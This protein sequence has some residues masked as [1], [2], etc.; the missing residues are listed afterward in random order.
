MPL[1]HWSWNMDFE[2][3]AGLLYFVSTFSEEDLN[4]IIQ[5]KRTVMKEGGNGKD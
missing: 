1:V 2:S 3:L 4:I 5:I